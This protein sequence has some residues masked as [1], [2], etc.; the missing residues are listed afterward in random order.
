M[1]ELFELINGKF[2]VNLRI[3]L[4]SFEGLLSNQKE[5]IPKVNQQYILF[6]LRKYITLNFCKWFAMHR[7]TGIESLIHEL[8]EIFLGF[9]YEIIWFKFT[10]Q[11]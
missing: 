10:D 11:S 2:A 9:L 5:W 4:I 1:I 7:F 6:P 3:F 8:I